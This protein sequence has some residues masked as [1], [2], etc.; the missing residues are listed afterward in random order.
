MAGS[1]V[2]VSSVK[3]KTWK[4]ACRRSR[5]VGSTANRIPPCTTPQRL[6]APPTTVIKQERDRQAEPEVLLRHDLLDGGKQRATDAGDGTRD[7]EGHQL[8]AGDVDAPRRRHSLVVPQRLDGAT[9]PAGEKAP[10]EDQH[11][12]EHADAEV[13]V[14]DVALEERRPRR[15]LPGAATGEEAD[16]EQRLLGEEPEGD[17]DQR[18]VQPGDAQGHAT[19]H[20]RGQPCR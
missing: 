14:L 2:A 13:G 1:H 9:G 17:R 19:Q 18:Q 16:V 20:E 4:L 6:P 5:S 7:D 10:V 11:E 15:S 8:V 12:E 3:G